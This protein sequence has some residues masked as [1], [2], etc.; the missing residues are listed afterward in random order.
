M[1]EEIKAVLYDADGVIQFPGTFIHHVET[2]HVWDE[3]N[4][5][6][7]IRALFHESN[8]EKYL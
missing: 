5:Y 3:K 1:M 6:S 4:Y 8:V 7:F 2:E